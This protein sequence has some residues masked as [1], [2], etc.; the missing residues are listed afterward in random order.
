V[1]LGDRAGV[2]GLQRPAHLELIGR[3]RRTHAMSVPRTIHRGNALDIELVQ[4]TTRSVTPTEAGEL[5]A[6]RAR[7]SSAPG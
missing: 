3:R 1:E 6:G 2:P 5:V 4:R 7:R